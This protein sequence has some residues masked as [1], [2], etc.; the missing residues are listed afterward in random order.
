MTRNLRFGSP[1]PPAPEPAAP[2]IDAHPP[3][4]N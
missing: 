1:Q 2:K 3:P 4:P